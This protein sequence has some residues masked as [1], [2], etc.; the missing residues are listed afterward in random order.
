MLFNFEEYGGM[1]YKPLIWRTNGVV[2]PPVTRDL[3]LTPPYRA[4]FFRYVT[5][6]VQISG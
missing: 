3:S 4:I 6:K 1:P 5:L 2:S